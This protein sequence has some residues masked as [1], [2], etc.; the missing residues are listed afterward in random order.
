[1]QIRLRQVMAIQSEKYLRSKSAPPMYFNVTDLHC[2]EEKIVKNKILA[3]ITTLS[4]LGSKMVQISG[5]GTDL[6]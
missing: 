4:F 6:G 2:L 1:M 5:L 3:S